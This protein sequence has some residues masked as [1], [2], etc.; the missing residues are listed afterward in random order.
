LQLFGETQK[1]VA[2]G[3]GAACFEEAEVP[4][5][6]FCFGSEIELAQTTAAT[7]FAQQIPNWPEESHMELTITWAQAGA[8]LEAE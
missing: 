8:Q 6:N 2:A 7:P 3:R 4:G 1:H 5:G